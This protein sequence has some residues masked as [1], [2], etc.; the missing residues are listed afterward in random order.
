MKVS[1]RPPEERKKLPPDLEAFANSDDRRI[2]RPRP[3]TRL[4]DPRAVYLV[5]GVANRHARSVYDAHLPLIQELV[6]EVAN[7]DEEASYALGEALAHAARTG[8]W[9]GRSITS[10]DAF[11][12]GVLGMKAA[13]ARAMVQ[14]TEGGSFP[15]P[16]ADRTVAIWMRVEAAFAEVGAAPG[17][18]VEQSEDGDLIVM[19]VPVNRVSEALTAAA[20]LLGPFAREDEDARREDAQSG[21]AERKSNAA[22]RV[23]A[24]KVNEGADVAAGA[25]VAV[26]EIAD[27]T[28]D[29]APAFDSA[30]EDASE[31]DDQQ[32]AALGD[33]AGPDD[34]DDDADDDADDDDADDDDDEESEEP[35][36][37]GAADASDANEEA[38]SADDDDTDE[39]DGDDDDDDARS[40]ESVAAA[41]PSK[42]ARPSKSGDAAPKRAWGS[43]PTAEPSDAGRGERAAGR[44]ERARPAGRDD[45][46]APQGDRG[47]RREAPRGDGPAPRRFGGDAPGGDRGPRRDGPRADGPPPRRFGGDAPAG[48]RGPP[49]RRFGGDAPGGDRGPRRDGPRG[50]GPPQRRFGGDAPAGDRGPR[51][52]G[53]PPGRFGG[54]APAGPRRD[55][56]RGDGPPQRRF[57]GDAPAGDRGPRRDGPRGDGPPQRR[58]GGDAPGG[59]RGPR[60]DGPPPRRFGGDAPAGDRGPRRD[61]PPPRRFGGDVPS[62]PRPK[63]GGFGA[64]KSGGFGPPKPRGPKKR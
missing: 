18:H 47:P 36:Q 59:D 13:T 35:L 3:A 46:A 30:D 5:S 19:A 43:R 6:A 64:P 28:D 52:D 39:D 22:W 38:D 57:G 7:G 17:S 8:L 42:P 1:R 26:G 56:P 49:P 21:A 15:E 12:E 10:F 2:A 41:P 31:E 62:P 51:R 4:D 37:V 58:F 27:A 32:V 60:R 53:P 23:D 16:L 25:K 55:G 20:Q 61:G 63:S 14:E 24:R 11:V 44:D 45:R 40:D 33:E 54:E 29:V 9:R 50:D 48:D 34:D